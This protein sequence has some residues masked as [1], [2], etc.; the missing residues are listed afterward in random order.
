M[1]LARTYAALGRVGP[2]HRAQAAA[3]ALQGQL[4]QAVE[5][6]QL[7]QKQ[8]DNDFYE[9]SVIDARLRELKAQLAQQ[10]EE[11]KRR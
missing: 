8:T 7:A 2:Q 1:L 5:Q 10:T 3:Y 6:L 11:A 4:Q 9:Q